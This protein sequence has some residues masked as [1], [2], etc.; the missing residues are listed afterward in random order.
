MGREVHA[1]FASLANDLK[2][3]GYMGACAIGLDGIEGYSHREFIQQCQRYPNLVPIA[4]FN[5]AGEAPLEALHTL[6]GMGY[7]GIKIHP[8]F[9]GLS[10]QLDTIGATLIAAGDADLTVFVCTYMHC[11]LSG[12]PLQDPFFSLVDQLRQAP[13]TRVVL[14]HGGDVNLMRY[15]ELVRFNSNLLLDLSLTLM[16]YPGSSID[17]DL[18]FLFRQFD[19]RICIGTDWP[20]YSP[21]QVRERFEFFARDLPE[22]RRHNI[23]FRN[24]LGFLGVNNDFAHLLPRQSLSEI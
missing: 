6:R 2:Q 1:D 3:A 8:R 20:E 9:S 19:R 17:L 5:P 15:A 16:K 21:Q 14:V 11:S 18:T 22:D 4:G 13:K 23:A 10:K 7:R 12:Y 24:L